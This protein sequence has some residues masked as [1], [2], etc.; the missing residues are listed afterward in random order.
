LLARSGVR[1][2]DICLDP[3]SW[4]APTMRLPDG[5]LMGLDKPAPSKK[6]ADRLA[7]HFVVRVVRYA[8]GQDPGS[9]TVAENRALRQAAPLWGAGS[10]LDKIY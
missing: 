2:I 10:R 5:R 6:I 9:H 8:D 3:D 4:E 7:Q 1:E